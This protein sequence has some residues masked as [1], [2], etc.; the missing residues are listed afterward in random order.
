MNNI[1]DTSYVKVEAGRLRYLAFDAIKSIDNSNFGKA[2]SAHEDVK[3]KIQE[4]LDSTNLLCNVAL[5]TTEMFVPLHIL[6]HVLKWAKKSQPTP[7]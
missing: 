5:A 7:K 4:L 2:R 6:N 3:E 1:S